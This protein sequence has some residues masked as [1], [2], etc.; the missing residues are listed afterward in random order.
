MTY[1]VLRV[2]LM[3]RVCHVPCFAT[4]YAPSVAEL[5]PAAQHGTSRDLP[6]PPLRFINTNELNGAC[7]KGI[8]FVDQQRRM[9]EMLLQ[10][11]IRVRSNTPDA[12]HFNFFKTSQQSL[13]MGNNALFNSEAGNG[14][15]QQ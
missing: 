15:L 4:P 14:L 5:A 10:Q 12:G 1:S 8:K 13:D 11:N 2:F 7:R 9:G 6:V 3:L